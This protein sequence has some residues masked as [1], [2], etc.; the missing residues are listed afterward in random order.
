MGCP[1][2]MVSIMGY[3]WAVRG[4]EISKHRRNSVLH[5]LCSGFGNFHRHKLYSDFCY[6][7][8]LSLRNDIVDR[9][10]ETEVMKSF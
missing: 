6:A 5:K 3:A 2:E 1:R 8:S 9:K 4:R 10:S 7:G